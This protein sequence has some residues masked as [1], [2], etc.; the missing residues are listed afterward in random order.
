MQFLQTHSLHVSG[1]VVRLLSLPCARLPGRALSREDTGHTTT[2]LVRQFT[3]RVARQDTPMNLLCDCAPKSNRG[4]S[5]SRKILRTCCCR[6]AADYAC[7]LL[8]ID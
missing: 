4:D 1:E 8:R 2:V 7:V 3:F 5:G 6:Q